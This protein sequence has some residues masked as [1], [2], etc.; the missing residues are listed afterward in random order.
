MNV[1]TSSYLFCREIFDFPLCLTLQQFLHYLGSR[2]LVPWEIYCS[3]HLQF[4][5]VKSCS[6]LNGDFPT[7][8]SGMF[9]TPGM[10]SLLQQITEN[11]QLMQNML[12][13]P[14]MRSIMQSLSQ[15]PDLAAQVQTPNLII[16]FNL[17]ISNVI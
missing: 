5:F 6:Y 2:R 17:N 1:G 7:A 13:A 3:V 11:P 4:A 12:S 15:N 14:Y 10:Q 8:G 9:N 16:L